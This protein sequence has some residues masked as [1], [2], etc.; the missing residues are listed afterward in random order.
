MDRSAW[1][2]LGESIAYFSRIYAGVAFALAL[3]IS[4][5]L[6]GRV[7]QVL[8]RLHF[9]QRVRDDGPQRHLQKEGTPTVGG[10]LIVGAVVITTG[11]LVLAPASLGGRAAF[12]PLK[13][14]YLW[15][16]AGATIAFGA[17]GFA[18]DWLKIKRGR[19]LGLKARQKLAL[20]FVAAAVFMLALHLSSWAEIHAIHA[21]YNVP[22]SALPLI[23]LGGL[24]WVFVMAFTSNA[25]N[26]ADGLD[27]L[28]AGLCAIAALGFAAIAWIQWRHEVAMFGLAVAGASLGF[29]WFNRHPARM[30]MGDV[31]S[32][33]LGGAL[34]GMA[35]VLG[36]PLALLGLCL[37][38]FI[39]AASVILQVISFKTTG[40]RVFKMS[41]IH[42]HFELCGWSERKVVYVFWLVQAVAAA[43]VVAWYL[44]RWKG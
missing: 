25:T 30:F 17:I 34:A 1:Y 40:K 20:Q 6:G 16:L 2:Y 24:F 38:P 36:Q 35:A 39:E 37:V 10:V 21:A 13:G 26:L 23:C 15:P 14:F 7:V 41:P 8:T 27:G 29:L 9:G 32:L 43:A 4:L 5:A 31:G 42:H 19:S 11:V 12:A 44:S 3:A 33:A 22:L 28:A 18:D